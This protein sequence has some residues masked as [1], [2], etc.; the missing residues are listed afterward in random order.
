MISP[1]RSQRVES[2]PEF[3]Q[4]LVTFSTGTIARKTSLNGIE[5]V[6][7]TEWLVR[8]STAPMGRVAVRETV[9]DSPTCQGG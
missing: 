5:Q 6:L 1:S 2:S 7:I 3:I 9:C 8:N 4:V